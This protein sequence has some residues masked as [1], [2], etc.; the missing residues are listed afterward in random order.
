MEYDVIVPAGII[1]LCDEFFFTSSHQFC[2]FFCVS[3][4]TVFTGIVD[5]AV[6]VGIFDSI[7]STTTSSN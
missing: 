1:L 5:P 3:V 6:T 2:S 4:P 7:F